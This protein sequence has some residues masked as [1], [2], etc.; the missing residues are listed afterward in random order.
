MEMKEIREMKAFCDKNQVTSYWMLNR[1]AKTRRKDWLQTLC[2][3]N[4]RRTMVLYC[5][6]LQKKYK[7]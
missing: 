4:G 5:R 7:D 2:T 1:Y 3:P 6:E